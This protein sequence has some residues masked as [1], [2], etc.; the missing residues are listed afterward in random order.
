V[1]PKTKLLAITSLI[2]IVVLSI[3][4]Y[5]QAGQNTSAQP[6]R[7]ACVGDS[8]TRG[9]GYPAK[10]QSLLG[11][12]YNVANF[13]VDGAT[14]TLSSERPYM[15]QSQFQMAQNFQP[16]IVVVMLGTNDANTNATQYDNTF[17]DDYTKLVT[18]FQSLNSNPQVWVAVSPPIQNNSLELSAPYFE[19]NI[20]PHLHH[21]A[22]DLNLPT[23]NVYDS[24]QNHPDFFMDG[25]HPDSDGATLI[26]CDVCI[27]ITPESWS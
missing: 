1:N 24:F 19:E 12:N 26:A 25:V 8:I 15:N 10:L 17:E 6:L 4:A 27:A 7:V 3:A 16:D 18:S 14:V 2:I 22:Q 20:I 21:V 11:S 23:I 5:S 9:S 13:G